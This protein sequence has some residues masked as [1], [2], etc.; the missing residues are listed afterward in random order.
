MR[1]ILVRPDG[2]VQLP[3]GGTVER[4]TLA[5]RLA[6]A[7]LAAAP[8]PVGPTLIVP[9]VSPAQAPP[10]PPK[11][12]HPE[13]PL[14]TVIQATSVALVPAGGTQVTSTPADLEVGPEATISNFTIVTLD[15]GTGS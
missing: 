15:S 2:V 1:Q 8:A 10:R 3:G 5:P 13:A 12:G 4:A 7:A 11:V 14:Q 9:A 6:L